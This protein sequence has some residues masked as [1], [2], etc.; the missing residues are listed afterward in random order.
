MG[1]R[2]LTDE[3]WAQLA[4]LLPPNGRR[5]GQWVEHRKIING[6]LWKLRTAAPWRDLPARYSRWQTGY[7]RF[8]RWRRD[9]TWDRLLAQ[10]LT[11]ADADGEVGWEVSVD[12]SSVR[13]HH[14]AAGARHQLSRADQQAD[15]VHPQAEALGCSRGGLTTKVHLACDSKG[16]P[17]SVVV[18][19]G[20]RHDSTQLGAVLDAIRV[21]RP[22]RCGRPRRRPTRVI[23]DKGYSYPTCRRLL[24]RRGI[25]QTIPGTARSATAPPSAARAATRL[26]C[27]SISGAQCRRAVYQQAQA[28]AQHRHAL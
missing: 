26:R 8:V 16:R 28:V 4:A 5:G 22:G 11:Q 7:D 18:T 9:G 23:A 14:H 12:S 20:Q 21:P 13:A 2:D 17:L 19:P 1:Q 6:I 15:T 10:V 25:K 27:H 24:R 3:A